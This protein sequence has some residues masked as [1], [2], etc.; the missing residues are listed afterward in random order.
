[1]T[2]IQVEEVVFQVNSTEF[3]V[4]NNFDHHRK[5]Q[6]FTDSEFLTTTVSVVAPK[7]E[8]SQIYVL[9]EKYFLDPKL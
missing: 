4:N 5:D 9:Y 6:N 3:L 7:R 1:L 2:E 8:A